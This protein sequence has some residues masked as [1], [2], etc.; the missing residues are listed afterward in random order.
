M[1]YSQTV[2]W[3]NGGTRA[4]WTHRQNHD[5]MLSLHYS[6]QFQHHQHHLHHHHHHH[7]HYHHHY[8]QAGLA[9]AGWGKDALCLCE[10]ELLQMV[11]RDFLFLRYCRS[12]TKV[13][14]S[15]DKVRPALGSCCRLIVVNHAQK[16][17][18]LPYFRLFRPDNQILSALTALYR[19]GTPF[20]L[21]Y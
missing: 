13:K 5:T 11:R 16:T 20:L 19:P 6:H 7:H 14:F 1:K 9:S 15:T 12:L 17:S 2:T 8:D 3:Q 4:R 21:F 18:K 10:G